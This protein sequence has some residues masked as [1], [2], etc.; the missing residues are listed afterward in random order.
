MIEKLISLIM[1]IIKKWMQYKR[2]T[3]LTYFTQIL[4]SRREQFSSIIPNFHPYVGEITD[5]DKQL[6]L[7]E[8][9][10]Q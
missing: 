2:R 8:Q 1:K 9:Q 3:H 10:K 6:Q 4:E 5:V 7:Q